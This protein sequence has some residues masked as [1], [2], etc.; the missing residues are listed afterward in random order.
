[1]LGDRQQFHPRSHHP[2][3]TKAGP[4]GLPLLCPPPRFVHVARLSL[5]AFPPSTSDTHNNTGIAHAAFISSP[6]VVSES[7]LTRFFQGVRGG[8][9]ERGRDLCCAW[10]SLALHCVAFD[11]IAAMAASLQLSVAATTSSSMGRLH[12]S[13]S[14]STFFGNTAA[15]IAAPRGASS[16]R[17]Y[18]SRLVVHAKIREIFMPALSSTMTEGKIVSWVK[19]EGDKLSKGA[20]PWLFVCGLSSGLD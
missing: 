4:S 10:L 3:T 9:R 8:E 20:E 6:S 17:R 19:S 12:S 18:G 13:S 11:C 15:L 2:T 7:E 14:S 16:S 5:N 1:M